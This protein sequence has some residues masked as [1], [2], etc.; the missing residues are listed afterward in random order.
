MTQEAEFDTIIVGAGFAGMYML[1]RLRKLGHR[2]LVIEK[3]SDVGGTWYWNRYPG[4]RCDVP[5]MEYSYQFDSQLQ[6]EWNWSERFSPQPEILRY[7][8]H[9]ADRFHLRPDILFNTTVVSAD[10]LDEDNTWRVTTDAGAIK[11][12]THLIAATGCL[13]SPN[14]AAIPNLGEFSG[15]IYHT[16][17]WPKAQIDFSNQHVAVIGTGSSAIQ[18]IPVIAKQAKH[19]TVFQRTANYAV[20]ARNAK[21]DP[22]ER[23]HFKENYAH[24]RKLAAANRNGQLAQ[25]YDKSALA[26]DEHDRKKQ[27]E[28]RWKQGGLPFIGSFNDLIINQESN[29]TA[30]EF[31]KQKI[32]ETVKDPKT[33]DILS[34]TSPIGCK[35]LCVDSGY[36][37]TFN[38]HN[39]SLIDITQTPIESIASDGIATAHQKIPLDAIVMATGFDAMTGSLIK[40]NI[41]GRNGIKLTDHWDAGPKTY[42]G[43][44]CSDFPNFF[45]ITGPGSPSVLT[46]M[47]PTIEQHVNLVHDI[48]DHA[49]MHNRKQIETTTEAQDAWTHHVNAIAAK[50]IYPSCNSWYLGANVAGKPRV[51]M[52]YVGFPDYVKRC[53]KIVEDGFTGFRFS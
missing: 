11:T 48:L 26:A 22:V 2:V 14:E 43:I 39:V 15:D 19:L 21:T 16:G 44:A 4:A 17:R 27:Y 42:L 25:P 10:Y 32:R 49:K 37:E 31:V 33:A 41:S 53:E 34:P 30:A 1:H 9:V 3:A 52:P 23:D 47:L 7:A 51:F 50:T 20:P 18:A 35:R 40:M 13:S 38:K 45:M 8:N 46:N 6:Q 36:Y 12:S 5:S 28:A 29:Q 24:Y